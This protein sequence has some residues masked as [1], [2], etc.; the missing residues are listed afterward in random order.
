MNPYK[1]IE[2]TH[3]IVGNHVCCIG[4]CCDWHYRT[5]NEFKEKTS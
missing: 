3:K 5:M 4:H 1:D 2:N